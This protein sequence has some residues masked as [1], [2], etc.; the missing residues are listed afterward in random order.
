MGWQLAAAVIGSQVLGSYLKS[1]AKKK[2]KVK[3]LPYTVMDVQMPN[4]EFV[5]VKRY[6]KVREEEGGTNAGLDAL[7][8]G[9][10]GV[11]N[12][13]PLVFGGGGEEVAGA[14]PKVMTTEDRLRGY[15]YENVKKYLKERGLPIG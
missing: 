6:H 8:S 13:A 1:K 15:D 2:N 7:G 10:L 12:A 4:G 5:K 3:E 11:S 9:L 14:A